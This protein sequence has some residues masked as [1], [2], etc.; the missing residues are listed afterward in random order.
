MKKMKSVYSLLIVLFLVST[1]NIT[2]SDAQDSS[3]WSLPEGAIAR[4][5]KGTIGTLRTRGQ[6]A[7][8]PDGSRLAVASKV[9]VWIYDT[10]TG[11]EVRLIT[12]VYAASV[13]FSPDSRTLAAGSVGYD[14]NTSVSLW[15]VATGNLTKML[16][17][18]HR[19]SVTSV[20]FSPDGSTLASADWSAVAL[21]YVATG[22]LLKRIEPRKNIGD[23]PSIAFSPDGTTLAVAGGGL[24]FAPISLWDVASGNL[25]KTLE[26]DAAYIVYSSD[27]TTIAGVSGFPAGI[28][29]LW[30]VETGRIRKTFTEHSSLINSVAFSPD[31]TTLASGGDHG[32]LFLWNLAT[33]SLAKAL[34]K[35]YTLDAVVSVAYSPDGTTL[36]SAT[37]GPDRVYLWDVAT[38]T[39]KKT[40]KHTGFVW[41]M[42]YSP[43]GTTIATGH[44]RDEGRLWN[45][46]T[47]DLTQVLSHPLGQGDG[48]ASL[49]FS[50][51]GRTLA[52]L[53]SHKRGT[54]ELWDAATGKHTRTL[55]EGKYFTVIA[56]SPDGKTLATG[57]RRAHPHLWDVATGNLIKELEHA[58][59]AA[60]L[61][62]SPDGRTLAS[63]DD[64]NGRVYLLDVATG[65]QIK[66]FE[67]AGDRAMGVVFSPDGRMLATVGGSDKTVRLWDVATA[68]LT[69]VLEHNGW[70]HSVAYSPDGNTVASGSYS[71]EV[72][73]GMLSLVYTVHLWDAATGPLENT[74]LG[75]TDEIS[76]LAFSPDGGT[77]ASGSKDGT[78]LLW[79]LRP[80]PSEPEIIAGDVNGDDIP[81]S[82]KPE[83]IVGDV[84]GDGIVN[85]LD[86]VFVGSRFGQT[87]ENAADVNG[88]KEVNIADLV[89]VAG[90]LGGA[91]GAPSASTLGRDREL[92]LTR[93]EVEQWLAQAQRLD[94]SDA[95]SE[96][97][98]HFLE[99]LLL[100]L[101]PKE[102]ALLANYPNPFNPETWIPYQLSKP[103]DV[104]VRIY[105]VDG[106]LV[107]T[108]S[109]GHKTVGI[110]QSRSRAVYWDGK[111]AVGEPVASGVYFYTLSA[112]DFV[113]TRKMLIRK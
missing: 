21:W 111:N 96:R 5:G 52:G 30:N 84:N 6:I 42:A 58:R 92:A 31:G 64:D 28:V 101:T 78:V 46:A 86:L 68:D 54:I 56:Y 85:I 113:A 13:A 44:L 97:G 8:S 60:S 36:A 109:L 57:H 48:F 94:L 108:L 89:L 16:T 43:D 26:G 103:A 49:V 25:T 47:A 93:T 99:Q 61:A 65:N 74:F 75:H 18:Q 9:G 104:T 72:F 11:A 63:R 110:Y 67:H 81:V 83:V 107:R 66:T 29:R 76:S 73:S 53:S 12:G 40:F 91:A 45:V 37:K 24:F 88:D 33:G 100:V 70:V 112:G 59:N 102:T 55:V 22:D 1:Q 17:G 27:G 87:G 79:G 15:D 4:L 77:L 3:R 7:Y 80:V 10:A 105:A 51:N 34:L 69:Q 98:I 95:I 41:G 32:T 38:G 20:A 71:R 50:P 90:A 23:N 39:Q 19:R 14:E 62:F 82:S 35:P 106:T 2:T